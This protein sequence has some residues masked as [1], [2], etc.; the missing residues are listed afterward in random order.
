MLLAQLLAELFKLNI[1]LVA[2]SNIAPEHLYQNG[3]QRDKFLPTIDLLNK[4]CKIIALQATTDYRLRTLE[5]IALFH[6]P[7]GKQANNNLRTYFYKLA[8]EPP[9]TD[10][11]IEVLGRQLKPILLAQ[12]II[13][14]DF[15]SLCATARSQNDYIELARIYQTIIVSDVPQLTDANLAAVRRI[16]AII[17][18]LYERKIKLLLSLDYPL[19]QLFASS[20]LEFASK[21]TLSRLHEMQTREYLSLAH[22]V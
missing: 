19:T 16:I 8:K 4:N 2:T 21:R 9:I 12:N 3:L 17:D 5:Q 11:T 14:F 13:W 1:I 18:E 22:L 15:E 10:G 20:Q 7:A 6:V